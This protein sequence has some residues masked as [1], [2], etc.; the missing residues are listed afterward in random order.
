MAHVPSLHRLPPSSSRSKTHKELFFFCLLNN[1]INTPY[2]L[3]LAIIIRLGRDTFT[4]WHQIKDE[5][6]LPAPVLV[7]EASMSSSWPSSSDPTG[8]PSSSSRCRMG[9]ACF[10]RDMLMIRHSAILAQNHSTRK[11]RKY[12]RRQS[13]D[14]THTQGISFEADGSQIEMI[15]SIVF[16]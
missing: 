7:V 9:R 1:C 3:E 8:P 6:N 13:T 5:W 14:E 10:L 2:V 15:K 12:F 4:S 11:W 16:L